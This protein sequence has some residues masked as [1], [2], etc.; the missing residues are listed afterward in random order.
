R[1]SRDWSSDVCSSDLTRLE[2]FPG[3]DPRPWDALWVWGEETL[4]L[5]GQEQLFALLI[6]PHGNLVDE[7]AACM[8]ADEAVAFRL[9]GAMR[10]QIGRASG[11][12]RVL[13]LA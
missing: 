10:L 7:L 12:E 9:D 4:S 2:G 13:I 6:E 5:E 11:R 3:D 1:F 8:S